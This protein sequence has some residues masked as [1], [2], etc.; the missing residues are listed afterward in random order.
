MRASLLMAGLALLALGAC[1]SNGTGDETRLATERYAIEVKSTPVEMKLAAHDGGLSANQ[2]DALRAFVADWRQADGGEITIKS[3]EHGPDPASAYRTANDARD[4]LIAQGVIAT[5]VRIDGY[6]AGGDDH[7]PV[8]VGFMRYLAKGPQCGQSW[9]NLAAVDDNRE[10]PE[11]GCSVTANIAAQIGNPAD[12]AE[13]RA[14]D[15][16]DSARRELV[17]EK[18]RQATIT[19]TPK[20]PQADGTLSDVGGH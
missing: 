6:E 12:L 2:A 1:A 18:Y 15:P 14:S 5:Q 10:Y 3:P 7:A 13:A 16:P 20:D 19:S 9:G 4:F 17:V 8:L 11:F